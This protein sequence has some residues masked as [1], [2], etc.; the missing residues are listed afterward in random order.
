MTV[1]LVGVLRDPNAK[2]F[3][4]FI[5]GLGLAVLLFHRPQKIH[6]VSAVPP[7]E[8]TDKVVRMDGKCYR[9]TMEDA[10]CDNASVGEKD[11]P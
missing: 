9:F 11:F 10:S 1:N 3:F 7:N 2:L 5:I 4:S 8:L 6:R